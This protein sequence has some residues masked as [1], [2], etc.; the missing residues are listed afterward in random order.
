MK[1]A[2]MRVLFSLLALFALVQVQAAETES[3]E[4]IWIDV[5]TVE[6]FQTG[7][8]DGALNIPHTE[9][10]DRIAATVTDLEQPIHL[11]C[12][13]GVRAGLALEILMEM[14]YQNVVNEGGYE[15][16]LA[17]QQQSQ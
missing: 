12:R 4:G 11:Y 17:K 16:I 10:A 3:K 8:L 15:A 14:G 6:E 1:T 2:S 13:S 7:H 5:R 9:I